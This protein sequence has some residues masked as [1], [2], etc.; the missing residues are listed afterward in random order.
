MLF[1]IVESSE[2]GSELYPKR[3]YVLAHPEYDTDTLKKE[4]IR[5]SAN[6]AAEKAALQAAKNF[7]HK[8][9]AR[10]PHNYFPE[11]NPNEEPINIWKHTAI[12]YSNWVNLVYQAT[13]FDISEIPKPH[14]S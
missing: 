12:M 4:Y 14:I 13:P 10:I 8:I 11:D 9:A 6:I 3:V 7:K 1:I 2:R 5:D